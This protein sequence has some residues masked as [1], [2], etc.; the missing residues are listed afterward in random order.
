M[1]TP[2]RRPRSGPRQRCQQH[3]PAAH[4]G[5]ERIWR[6]GVSGHRRR[7]AHR[8]SSARSW[9]SAEGAARLARVREIVEAHSAWPRALPPRPPVADALV[10]DHCPRRSR[11]GRR[12]PDAHRHERAASGEGD[13]P[14]VGQRQRLT[15]T[16]T[17]AHDSAPSAT[18]L[19]ASSVIFAVVLVRWAHAARLDNALDDSAPQIRRRSSWHRPGDRRRPAHARQPARQQPAALPDLLNDAQALPGPFE[20]QTRIIKIIRKS[21]PSARVTPLHQARCR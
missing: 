7:R 1:P 11:T 4:A 12:M 9:P 3:D 14:T 5:A 20:T 15:G 6:S 10:P 16:L 13:A 21:I 17:A 8:L 18:I 2:G 19:N